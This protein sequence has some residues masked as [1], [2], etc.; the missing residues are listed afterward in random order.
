M[1]YPSVGLGGCRL[2]HASSD[3]CGVA[4]RFFSPDEEFHWESVTRTEVH[5]ISPRSPP[6]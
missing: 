4:N 1:R 3:T 6:C 2:P 5:S